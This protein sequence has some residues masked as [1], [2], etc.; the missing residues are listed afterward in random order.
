M[1]Y[2]LIVP[3]GMADHPIRELG[4]RTPVEAAVTPHLD[5]ACSDG[6]LGLAHTTC[7]AH[8][9]GSD[10][11]T[12]CLL[13]Y[14]PDRYY[15]GRAPLEAASL[16][17]ELG[18]RDLAVR[19]NLIT[20]DEEKLI[21]YS[22]GSIPTESA[23]VLMK[24][25]SAALGTETLNFY[26]GV[27]YRNLLVVRGCGPLVL[28]AFPPHDVMGRRLQ[29]IYPTGEGS[30]LLTGLIRRSRSV[31]ADHPVNRDRE[32][33]GKPPAN[34]IWLWGA[35]QKPALPTFSSRFGRSGA[36]VAA[37]DLI[38]GI[39]RILGWDVLTVE[40]ATGYFDTNYRGKAEAGIA[41]LRD[42]DFVFVHVEAPD[43]A[44][45]AG[46]V[47]EKIRAI[48]NVDRHV[49]GPVREALR[50]YPEHRLLI[51]P[52]H[53]TPIAIRTHVKEPVPF[54]LCGSGITSGGPSTYSEARARR[55]TL[56]LD[57]GYELMD[58]FFDLRGLAP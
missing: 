10:V 9:P 34:L 57:R 22:A 35:G 30:D 17:I 21:D 41:A 46:D 40:G 20:A 1:K 50:A 52:D 19:C 48:E 25:V 15:T 53:P 6:R 44:G 37:V 49:I 45:H 31:L 47:R 56:K 55:S 11:A 28:K 43:E 54:A 13:G 58:L 12:M 5:A 24:A 23:H 42:H 51:L 29:D 14:N 39:G 16:G 27:S 8:S 2:F 4:G 26:P 38:K 18:P 32:R 3:D 36:V 33:S 7:S